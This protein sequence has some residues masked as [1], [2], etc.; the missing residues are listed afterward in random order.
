[1]PQAGWDSI[2]VFLPLSQKIR[3]IQ[4]QSF[5]ISNSYKPNRVY[6]TDLAD[7]A[8]ESVMLFRPNMLRDLEK[9]SCLDG[10]CVV[11]SVWAG[12]LEDKKNQWFA[13]RLKDRGIPLHLIHTSGHASISDLQRMRNAFPDAV[14]VPVHL[15][16]RERFT[17]LFNNVQL[18]AD[19]D[20]W[21]V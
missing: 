18:R 10:S 4:T 5:H 19:A 9:A 6:D 15:K 21:E 20:W 12:Y 14:A 16:D 8:S 17:N 11:N 2:S 13:M 7:A 1:L 3:I